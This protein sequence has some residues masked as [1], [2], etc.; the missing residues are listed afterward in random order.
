VH[1]LA[2][3]KGVSAAAVCLA[4][5]LRRTTAVIAGARDAAQAMANATRRRRGAV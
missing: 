5:V 3:A 1:P 2:R 4:W